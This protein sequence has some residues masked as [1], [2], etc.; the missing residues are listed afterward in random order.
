MKNHEFAATLG[1]IAIATAFVAT[2]AIGQ[3]TM[4]IQSRLFGLVDG[5]DVDLYTLTNENGM[6]ASIT[7][8]GATV[9]DLVVPSSDGPR[10]V[11]LGFDSLKDYRERSPY[12][13]CMV[14][15]VG[16]RVA[17]GR[18]ELDGKTYSLARNN[19]PNHLHGGEKG[20]DK[21][22]WDVLAA[23]LTEKGVSLV[24][25]HVSPDGEEGYPGTLTTIVEYVLTNDD[26]LVIDVSATTDASTPVN[27]VHHSYWNLAGHDSGTILDHELT[28]DASRYTPIDDSLIPIGHLE[29][30]KGT[31]L[32]FREAKLIG[33]DIGGF[34]AK[35]DE[36]GGYDHNL[37]LDGEAGD[38]RRAAVLKDSDSGVT[39]EI[40]TDQPGIQF[41]TG[42]Y[43]DD[44]AGKKGAVYPRHGALCLETQVFP[45]AI[46]RRGG[47]GWP[48][49]VLRPGSTYRH[50]MEH[51]FTY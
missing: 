48:D 33:R 49:P 1:A 34:P 41:Y 30:V 29:P 44:L 21:K 28:L 40:W 42:N 47:I 11:A 16:N 18:F 22:V 17:G 4:S 10:D 50:R 14:G 3:N 8:Y 15:R 43:L 35:G 2:N 20:F 37:V 31:P 13:G 27:V 6:T 23:G 7:S 25:R 32:D 9:V 5:Q 12:F 45:D 51:R 36:P 38:F 46:N 26:A 19:G 39:M 24:M